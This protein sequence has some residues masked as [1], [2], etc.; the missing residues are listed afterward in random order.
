MTSSSPARASARSMP[1]PMEAASR[2][3]ACDRD[4]TC[5]VATVSGSMRRIATS[6]MELAIRRISWARRA[7]TPVTK[8]KVTGPSS[9]SSV[10]TGLG[11]RNEPPSASRMSALWK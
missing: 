9:D 8:T 7:I 11:D 10:S 3:M 2:R 1:S 5:S 6:V 4:T